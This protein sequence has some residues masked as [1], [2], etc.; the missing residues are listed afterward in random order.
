MK[1]VKRISMWLVLMLI[2]AV[3]VEAIGLGFLHLVG[4]PELV[5][6]LYGWSKKSEKML[7]PVRVEKT[8]E[9][10]YAN[11][12]ESLYVRGI[13]DNVSYNLAE[14]SDAKHALLFFCDIDVDQS[15]IYFNKNGM[16]ELSAGTF[17]PVYE[18]HENGDGKLKNTLG[19][20]DLG[21]LM[22]NDGAAD[23][24]ELVENMDEEPVIQINS[25]SINDNYI[26]TPA[27]ITVSG[28]N[29]NV[30]GKYEFPVGGNIIKNAAAFAN[31]GNKTNLHDDFKAAS[32]GER[33]VDKLA[34]QT[35]EKLD[36][37]SGDQW[38]D[39][40]IIGIGSYTVI[41]SENTGEWGEVAVVKHSFLRS[42]IL[43]F[44]VIGG[45]LTIIFL[46]FTHLRDKKNNAE[47]N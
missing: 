24:R 7:T 35:A 5:K 17:M 2:T 13:V 9:N 26:I 32:S 47:M 3:F 46:V 40:K 44:S 42:F 43:Y 27:E 23:F 31:Y 21:K 10:N 37:S 36:F 15:I 38:N 16:S 4:G 20:I 41:H 19:L 34:K 1:I 33:K 28:Q 45:I 8:E 30:L 12:L 29:G 39:K 25:Y 6:S 14:E 22:K 11:G 18:K